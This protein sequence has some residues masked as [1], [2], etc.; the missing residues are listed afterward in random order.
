[1]TKSKLNVA[2]LLRSILY[3][4][5]KN[6]I[7]T[8]IPIGWTSAYRAFAVETFFKDVWIETFLWLI[9][10]YIRIMLLRIESLTCYIIDFLSRYIVVYWPSTRPKIPFQRRRKC[11][12]YWRGRVWLTIWDRVIILWYSHKLMHQKRVTCELHDSYFHSMTIKHAIPRAAEVYT[13]RWPVM[14][15]YWLGDWTII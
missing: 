11:I 1:M 13:S 4:W 9:S 14:G 2:L 10:S 15:R 7:G 8:R 3:R 5:T 6:K 12:F